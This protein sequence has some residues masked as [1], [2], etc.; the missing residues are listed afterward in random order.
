MMNTGLRIGMILCIIVCF[1]FNSLANDWNLK[2]GKELLS[3][4]DFERALPYLQQAAKTDQSTEAMHLL[5][6]MYQN[7]FGVA[8]DSVIAMNMYSKAASLDYAPAIYRLGVCY[9]RGISVKVDLQEAMKYYQQA[10]EK[11]DSDAQAQIAT[12]YSEG[13]G[14]EKSLNKAFLWASQAAENGNKRACYMLGRMFFWGEGCEP[15]YSSAFKWFQK[16]ADS[17]FAL[18]QYMTA[19][20]LYEGFA[21]SRNNQQAFQYFS[22]AANQGNI[23]AKSYIG[24]MYEYGYGTEK[25]LKRAISNYREASQKGIPRGQFGLGKLYVEG[26]GVDKNIS[27]GLELI[28]EAS[29]QG[30]APADY[31]QGKMYESGVGVTVD[32]PKA[33]LFYT[34][35]AEKGNV[36]AQKALGDIYLKENKTDVALGWYEKAVG[37][38]YF[39]ALLEVKKMD[40]EG[41]EQARSIMA[42]MESRTQLSVSENNIQFSVSDREKTI[43]I[44]SNTLLGLELSD[45]TVQSSE[46]WLICHS[47]IF[48]NQ[49]TLSVRRNLLSEGVFKTTVNIYTKFGND[50]SIPVTVTS[51][52][53]P[54]VSDG[55]IAYY[56]FDEQNGSDTPDGIGKSLSLSKKE[57]LSLPENPLFL[58]SSSSFSISF[59]MKNFEKGFVMGALQPK[60]EYYYSHPI[61]TITSNDR[62]AFRT[63]KAKGLGSDAQHE[64]FA[65]D[66]TKIKDGKWHLITISVG[67]TTRTKTL[68]VD[69]K[70]IETKHT[71]ILDLNN[72]QFTIGG[73]QH[74]Y[75]GMNI[76]IDNLRFYS[77]SLKPEEVQIIFKE[78][79]AQ[80]L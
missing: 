70:E 76:E 67:G 73:S 3:K 54:S 43:F 64:A 16:S 42:K 15:N 66:L 44:S 56:R 60:E 1:Q 71:L 46:P 9:E 53:K 47:S 63:C 7:G 74:Q 38:K 41:N 51:D 6:I 26:K 62:L 2:K 8:K 57:Q 72:R 37:K 68:F 12:L 55:L 52:G 27:V 45:Y 61:L 10:A 59:W 13:K 40:K 49:I 11:G 23:E 4:E 24:E 50:I 78:E 17:G 48:F 20:M 33:I 14:V 75:P 21:P 19:C 58:Q 25:D 79:G 22:D 39:P 28:T 77:R 34:K 80:S 32:L 31:Y 69:G 35:A 29:E 18:G 5:G 65:Y 36:E 30:Y